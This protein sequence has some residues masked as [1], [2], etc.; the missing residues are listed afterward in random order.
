MT[1]AGAVREHVN[2]FVRDESIKF[3]GG[4]STD[5]TDNCEISIIPA[6]SGGREA[7]I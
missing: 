3:T 6:I 2:I 5:L 1:E 7:P 4:L